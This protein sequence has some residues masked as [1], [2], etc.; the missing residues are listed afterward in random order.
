MDS[1]DLAQYV[2]QERWLLNNG[3]ISD[4]AKNNLYLYG[5]LTN[6]DIK[7]VELDID[8]AQKIV[9]YQLY[10]SRR[11]LKKFNAYNRL[12][13]ATSLVGLWR[14]RKLLKKEGNL[15]FSGMLNRFV[16]DFCGP[17]WSAN[18]SVR[19]FADYKDG[20][21]KEDGSVQQNV[22]NDRRLD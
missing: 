19:N 2:D 13:T 20:F 22:G 11:L 9:Y 3:L 16:K 1:K 18:V 15:N 5:A 10:V 12:S 8:F 7:A 21:E 17:Y 6:M 4:T 14:L